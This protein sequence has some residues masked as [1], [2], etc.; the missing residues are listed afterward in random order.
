[1]REQDHVAY[2]CAVGEQH[3]QTVDADPFSGSGRQ[4]VFQC[5]H[6]I[7]VLEHRLF[8]ARLFRGHL[9]IETRFLIFRIVQ[10]GKA[11]GDLA[12]DDEQFEALGNFRVC[13]AAASQRRDFDRVVDNESRLEQMRFGQFFEQRKLQAANGV[14]GVVFGFQVFQLGD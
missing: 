5:A 8:I 14:F 6:E 7:V 4:A 1:V 10:F 3:H 2:V 9:R 13:I 12:S 11:V